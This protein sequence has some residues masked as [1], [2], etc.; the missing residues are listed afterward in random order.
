MGLAYGFSIIDLAYTFS[1]WY[2]D[3]AYGESYTYQIVGLIVVKITVKSV[4]NWHA[5]VLTNPRT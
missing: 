5:R 1:I 2:I 4:F 3:L